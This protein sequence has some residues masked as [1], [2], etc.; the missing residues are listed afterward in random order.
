MIRNILY[1]LFLHS[2]LVLLAYFT[3]N[4]TP[5][6]EV[7][8]A[9]KVAISFQMKVGNSA[10]LNLTPKPVLM[11]EVPNAIPKHVEAQEVAQKKEK[12]PE[13]KIVQPKKS[14]PKTPPRKHLDESRKAMNKQE[15]A[16]SKPKEVDAKSVDNKV[17]TLDKKD[18]TKQEP[19]KPKFAEKKPEIKEVKKIV[20]DLKKEL[21]KEIDKE[22]P[23]AEE[24]KNEP[25]TD[26]SNE[27]DSDESQYS[28]TENS[29]EG[30]DLLA[31]EK[32]NIQTQIKRCYKKALAEYG[33]GGV[34]IN[35]HIFVAKDGFIDLDT[36]IFKNFAGYKNETQKNSLETKEQASRQDGF[37]EYQK[38]LDTV[39]KA[40]KFCSP[41]RNLPQDKYDIWK[42][43][44][45]Q[46]D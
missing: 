29:I 8:K 2:I 44:D 35:A 37:E 42:E 39:K 34:T 23:K 21:E 43:I 4:F 6:V 19:D 14:K 33:G 5:P 45:L 40:L 38:T 16:K 7:E 27:E 25:E 41:I 10:S 9:S 17:K 28:F 20:K 22:Q 36:V 31:R 3:F 30:L 26:E 11:P 46:F 32:F 15:V 24:E 18:D 1:S 13:K 12:T